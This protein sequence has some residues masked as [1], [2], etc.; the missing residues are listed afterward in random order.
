M[1]RFGEVLFT[2]PHLLR[3]LLA[4]VD[5]RLHDEPTEEA[6][7]RIPHRETLRMEPSVDAIRAPLPE[8]AVVRLTAH[9]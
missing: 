3:C 8:L 9:D 2:T 1:L 5:I 7:F 6:A 4:L